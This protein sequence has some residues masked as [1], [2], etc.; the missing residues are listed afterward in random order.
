[1]PSTPPFAWF[2]ARGLGRL[3]TTA[4]RQKQRAAGTLGAPASDEHQHSRH[5]WQAA[6]SAPALQ[7]SARISGRTSRDLSS[8]A[9]LGGQAAVTRQRCSINEAVRARPELPARLLLLRDTSSQLIWDLT[10]AF[11]VM[12]S[13]FT[14]ARHSRC[15]D[16]S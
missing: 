8:S 9:S 12:R 6:V 15:I 7:K 3:R 1:M 11:R 4:S 16:T 14:C 2:A 13:P 10:L 5:D